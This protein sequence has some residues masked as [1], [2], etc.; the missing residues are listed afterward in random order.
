MTIFSKGT[1][2]KADGENTVT[3]DG[4]ITTAGATYPQGVNFHRHQIEIDAGDNATG[5][6]TVTGTAPSLSVDEP[7]YESDNTTPLVINLASASRTFPIAPCT[8]KNMIFDFDT[9]GG[10]SD[11][12]I[13][14]SSWDYS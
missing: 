3:L 7:V 9:L 13:T 4:G 2:T 12:T 14:V 1:F 6:I 8:L 5:T 10:T 11:V